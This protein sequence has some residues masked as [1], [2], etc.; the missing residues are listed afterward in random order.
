MCRD[1]RLEI[2]IAILA[3]PVA[4]ILP[5]RILER[6][7]GDDGRAC[8][9]LILQLGDQLQVG[10]GAVAFQQPL[11]GAPDG[12]FV[13]RAAVLDDFFDFG[14]IALDGLEGHEVSFRA[15]KISQTR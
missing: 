11:E 10:I 13:A 1:L 14:V 5:Q 9:R 2:V 15:S 8:G 6:A 12:A 4:P 3:L 7:I